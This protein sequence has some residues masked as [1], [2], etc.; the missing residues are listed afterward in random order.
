MLSPFGW[1]TAERLAEPI[2]ERLAAK[3]ANKPYAGPG[4]ARWLM[5]KRWRIENGNWKS[6]RYARRQQARAAAKRVAEPVAE[7]IAEGPARW[8]MAKR[9]Q[10]VEDGSICWWKGRALPGAHRRNSLPSPP[11]IAKP[12]AEPIALLK[13]ERSPSPGRLE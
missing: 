6:T 8:L 9:W 12:I 1:S 5:A 7:P 4:P 2:A 11:P 3:R 13:I 10:V